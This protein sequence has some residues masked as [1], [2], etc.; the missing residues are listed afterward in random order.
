[1]GDSCICL[2]GFCVGIKKSFVCF[3][4]ENIGGFFIYV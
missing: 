2:K 1:M 4:L 3:M